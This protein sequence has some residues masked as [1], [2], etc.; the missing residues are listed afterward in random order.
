MP[1]S[2]NEYLADLLAHSEIH[3]LDTGHF[4]WE[5]ASD[6]YGG[7][8]VYWVTGGFERVDRAAA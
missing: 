4:A 5:Q 6:D 7:L 2:N 1:W 3:P 8:I